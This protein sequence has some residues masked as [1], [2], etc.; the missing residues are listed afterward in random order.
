MSR[1]SKSDYPTAPPIIKFVPAAI[2]LGGIG[3]TSLIWLLINTRPFEAGYRWLFFLAWFVSITGSA[4]PAVAF[5]NHRFP[6]R[7]PAT[8][9]V[10]LRQSAWIGLFAAAIA[11]LQIGRFVN[12]A[13]VTLLVVG[14]SAIEISIRFRERGQWRA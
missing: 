13:I 14:I 8:Q 4:L 9:K 6:G 1:F 5:L 2:L 7:I 10:I 12:L 3:W 11:W